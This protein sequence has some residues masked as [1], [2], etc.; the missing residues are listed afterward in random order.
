M[1]P[2]ESPASLHSM[3]RMRELL[4]PDGQTTDMS[5]SKRVSGNSPHPEHLYLPSRPGQVVRHPCPLISVETCSKHL[6]GSCHA[7]PA[8]AIVGSSS[9]RAC[10]YCSTGLGSHVP[11]ALR[12]M[13]ISWAAR[14]CT[15]VCSTSVW[16]C[17]VWYIHSP[18]VGVVG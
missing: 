15:P 6:P 2:A 4:A 5:P 8:L 7:A 16:V 3:E 12:K 10:C 1:I 14:W 13:G 18:L 9:A 11:G 17:A